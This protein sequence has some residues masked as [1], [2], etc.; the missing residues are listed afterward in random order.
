MKNDKLAFNLPGSSENEYSHTDPE[1]LGTDSVYRFGK[2]A[3]NG[4]SGLFSVENRGTQPVQIYNTQTETSG[5]PD[6]T[7]YDVE[8]GS[9]L[10]EDSPSLPLST[11]NQLPCGLEIDTHGVPVQEIEYDVTLTINAVAASD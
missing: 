1:G 5:V 2:D 9:T 3:R 6:V 10:T 4:T 8:T 7:M 11:G